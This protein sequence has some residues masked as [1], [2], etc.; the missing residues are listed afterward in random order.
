MPP[1]PAIT[2]TLT[3]D[4]T[5]SIPILDYGPDGVTLDNTEALVVSS[6]V[7]TVATAAVDP[8]NNRLVRVTA[9][10]PGSA[11]VSIGAGGVAFPLTSAITV[12]PAPNLSRLEVGP[13]GITHP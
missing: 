1:I 6:N 11:L 10:A 2:L 8:G 7:P 4:P 12:N 13:A 3:T 9:V 5:A